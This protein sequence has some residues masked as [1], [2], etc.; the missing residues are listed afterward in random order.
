M[1]G[2]LNLRYVGPYEIV[3]KLNLITYR[4]DLPIDLEHVH[5]AF[6]ISQLRKCAPDTDHAIIIGPIEITEDL[7]YE[8]RP[9]QILDHR[10]KQLRNKQIHLVKILWA[11]H[12]SLEATWETEED[13]R[14]KCSH[15]FEVNLHFI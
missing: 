15:L 3:E 11:K 14:T 12:T 13:M 2:K 6:Y 5:N 7:T 9:V 8:E 10:I 1:R 4:L